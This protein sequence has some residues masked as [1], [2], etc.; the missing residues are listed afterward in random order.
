[1][2]IQRSRV[3]AP[4]IAHS[5]FGN[6]M[7]L[8]QAI[9]LG[10]VQGLTE[11]LPISSSGHLI[12]FQKLLNL[13]DLDKYVLFDLWCHV[14]TLLAVV[15]IFFLDIK[16]VLK[17]RKKFLQLFI[18]TLPLFP[19]VLAIKPLKSLFNEPQYLGYFFLITAL[20]LFF[21]QRYAK[22]RS[23]EERSSRF[24]PDAFKIGCFQALAVLPGVSRSGSTISCARLL[25]WSA[26]EAVT[27]SFLLSIPA[28]LGAITLE[29]GSLFLNKS[30]ALPID[31]S[32][33]AAGCLTAFAT[34]LI[35]LKFLI[36]LAR[37]AA[38]NLF[39]WYCAILGLL[40]LFLFR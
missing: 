9:F 30:K 34:G 23:E 22:I 8:L 19:L 40:T 31:V 6:L 28:I 33:Y 3:R 21:G 37:K 29:L 4:L 5:Y 36:H 14:G 32:L 2:W 12:L 35:A 24:Y 7:S 15:A 10:I 13:N 18:A 17:D 11:F 26:E 25:G 38:F 27:F 39:I 16:V 20:L 1:M